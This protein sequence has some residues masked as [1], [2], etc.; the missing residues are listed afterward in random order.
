MLKKVKRIIIALLLIITLF[1]F[2]YSTNIC[3]GATTIEILN[4]VTNLAGGIVSILLWRQR[5]IITAI[6]M[7]IDAITTMLVSGFGVNDTQYKNVLIN[8][9][10]IF[11]NKYKLL[12]INFFKISEAEDDG[13]RQMRINIAQW[14]HVMQGISAAAMLVV[15]VYVGIRMALSTLAEDK[16]K[17]KKMLVDWVV[18]VVLLFSMHWII[19]ATV[20]TNNAIVKGLEVMFTS[21]QGDNASNLA[22]SYLME[23]LAL[24]S[25]L[26]IGIASFSALMV[27][28]M[29]VFQ[30]LMFLFGYITR[31][32]KVA[33][34]I[35]I[36]PLIVITY[37]IDKMGDG[38]SQAFNAWLKE[39]VFTILIQPFHCVIYFA[40]CSVSM[41]LLIMSLT[42]GSFS[43]NNIG[44]LIMA[45]LTSLAPGQLAL[46][47]LSMGILAVLC[48]KFINDAEQIVRHIFHFEDDSKGSLAV[49]AAITMGAIANAQK[50]GATARKGVNGL[51]SGM[52]AIKV[53]S[54]NR[55]NK[56]QGILNESENGLARKMGGVMKA[57]GQ[58]ADEMSK[59]ISSTKM[60][61][62]L[63]NST[64][65]VSDS[66]KK[67]IS[68]V[69]QFNEK[70]KRKLNG[71]GRIGQWM[72][73]KNSLSHALGSMAFMASMASGS[74]VVES[75]GKGAAVEKAGL[76]F[77]PTSNK[78]LATAQSDNLQEMEQASYE[79]LKQSIDDEVDNLDKLNKELDDVG[80]KHS[81]S[82]FETHDKKAEGLEKEAAELEEEA[83][84]TFSSSDAE[85]LKELEKKLKEDGKLGKE[86]NE[87][88]QELLLKK[89]NAEARREEADN[90]RKEANEEKRI[91]GLIK[92]RE[93]TKARVKS[94]YDQKDD[95]FTKEA[96]K[97][98]MIHYRSGASA[99]EMKAAAAEVTQ[100]IMAAKLKRKQKTGPETMGHDI[101]LDDD[102]MEEV[103]SA[104][105][106]IKNALTNAT[107]MHTGVD[108][109]DIISR[110]TDLD[111][112]DA[113][114]EDLKTALST[115]FFK[116]K[117]DELASAWSNAAKY[118]GD[119][120]DM[121][122]EMVTI[123]RS[124]FDKNKFRL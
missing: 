85:T 118:D 30:T 15:L 116:L 123:V 2:V 46:D 104:N 48:L 97:A 98:R 43:I 19:V 72:L 47:K 54:A 23:S 78:N 25:V 51:K 41:K 22:V 91:S 4:G 32:I 18:G 93:T 37:A 1:E 117:K 39:F 3:Y 74:G 5:I 76:E 42:G 44:D 110:T 107:Y 96:I 120:D 52:S 80:I 60:A 38:K 36:S 94:L 34:L 68:G 26:S 45:G 92:A 77:F 106:Y 86:D 119:P 16:A 82:D 21:I 56:I 73:Q 33:F 50:I 65:A 35:V 100:L 6:T 13:I 71:S 9:Y 55:M 29:I 49:G 95:F 112:A 17:Y 66:V 121:D 27:F 31:M 70:F 40:F 102:E 99:K 124:L 24:M 90:K 75:L 10:A 79:D 53:D 12:D 89:A 105:E 122:E 8:P 87:K 59:R 115:Y 62:F 103:N 109:D 84:K 28:V 7:G 64:S 108:F 11:F 69:R 111:P 88:Y 83:D 101:E 63:G 67:K 14:Y 20:Y 113:I 114:Y 81:D 58:G 57:A 61:Q